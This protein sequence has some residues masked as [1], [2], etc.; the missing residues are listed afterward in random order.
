VLLDALGTLVALE[1]PAPLLRAELRGRFGIDVGVGDAERAF[2]AEIAFYRR[3]FDE[4]RDA[5]SVAALRMRCAGALRDA[6]PA[7]ARVELGPLTEALLGSLRFVAFPDATPALGALRGAGAR[8]IVVSNWDWSLRGVL[9]RLGLAAL[10]DGII[11]SAE[12]GVRKPAA[13]I[14]A[15]GLAL[16][17]VGAAD[18]VH[19]G[20]SVA[21]DV[22]GARAMGIA[23]VLVSRDGSPGP[24]GV[25][26]VSSLLE[27]AAPT[28]AG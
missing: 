14:F 27:L 25:R 12:V 5:A 16:A 4:G 17:G 24:P 18:A 15:R 28:L 3:H 13:A 8:L 11:I 9:E 22:D 26:T 1:P 2:A 20:D 7:L 19:V 10:V 6:L 23:P 21:E